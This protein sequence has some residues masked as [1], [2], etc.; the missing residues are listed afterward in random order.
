VVA[1]LAVLKAGGACVPIDPSDPIGRQQLIAEDAGLRL[2]ISPQAGPDEA[3]A[4]MLA[5]DA[6]GTPVNAAGPANPADPANIA[7]VLYTSDSTDRPTGVA[8]SHRA[9]VNQVQRQQRQGAAGRGRTLHWAALSSDAFYQEMLTTLSVGET[10]VLV[11]EKVRHDVERLLDVIEGELIQ[12]ILMPFVALQ[13]L[14]ELAVRLDRIPRSLRAVLTAGEPLRATPA[15]RA[16]FER[17]PGCTLY[18]VYGPVEVHVATAYPLGDNP[19]GWSALPPIGRP[20]ANV[21]T[22]VLDAEL[23]P[24][25]PAVVGELF[26]GGMALARGYLGRPELTAERFLPDPFAAGSRMYRTGDRVRRNADGELEFLGRSDDQ[27]WIRGFRVEVVEIEATLSGSPQV[28]DCAVAAHRYGNGDRHLAAYVV[29]N[30]DDPPTATQLRAFLA[31]RLP[32]YMVPATYLTMTELPRTLSG[33][34]SLE[35]LPRPDDEAGWAG[36][37][38]YEPPRTPLEASVA[39]IWADALAVPRVGR[40]DNFFASGGH[41]VL[42]VAVVSRLGE[43][44]G[45]TVTVRTLFEAPT[46]ADLAGRLGDTDPG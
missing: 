44:T 34:L 40:R 36:A 18:N 43:L 3:A 21:R 27:V 37:A 15:I 1:N 4:P 8:M 33:K 46:V 31:A 10:I 42:A 22:Y 6:F 13:G 28:S 35:R 26:V 23:R 29:P 7:W 14:A 45:R 12:R 20:L 11:E 16:F 41:S 32:D 24:V 30:A 19:R 2:L 39:A 9:L 17:M 38:E 25:P 5:L